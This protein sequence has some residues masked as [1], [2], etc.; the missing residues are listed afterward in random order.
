MGELVLSGAITA[1]CACLRWDVARW[2]FCRC[3][4]YLHIF[5]PKILNGEMEQLKHATAAE[6][7]Q[8]ALNLSLCVCTRTGVPTEFKKSI[9][10]EDTRAETAQIP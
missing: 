2:K 6:V 1:A 4:L 3:V 7:E 10:G 8:C 5:L 9:K